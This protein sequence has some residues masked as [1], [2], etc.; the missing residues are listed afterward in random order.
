MHA[1]WA[2]QV[3]KTADYL[4]CPI[5]ITFTLCLPHG[6]TNLCLLL[7]FTLLFTLCITLRFTLRFTLHFTLHLNY[8]IFAQGPSY[9]M[10]LGSINDVYVRH[11][12]MSK[13]SSDCY[14]ECLINH[15]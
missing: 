10:K 13:S 8:F 9:S 5:N 11:V 15:F 7:C 14:L 1:L 6:F 2:K 3:T 4:A 12:K